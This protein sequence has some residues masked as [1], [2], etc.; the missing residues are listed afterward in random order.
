MSNFGHTFLECPD[1]ALVSAEPVL[2][3]R[4]EKKHYVFAACFVHFWCCVFMINLPDWIDKPLYAYDEPVYEY[5]D[6]RELLDVLTPPQFKRHNVFMR[7]NS[8][9]YV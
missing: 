4:I 7:S 8:V 3:E 9:V 2:Y 6:L 1:Y 5:P